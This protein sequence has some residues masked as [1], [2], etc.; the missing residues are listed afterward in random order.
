M[1]TYLKVLNYYL[2][3]FLGWTIAK[4]SRLRRTRE[5]LNRR[6]PQRDRIQF[7]C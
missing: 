6:Q 7:M 3:N 2:P 1:S 4:S 5:L